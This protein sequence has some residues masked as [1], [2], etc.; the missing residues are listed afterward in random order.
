MKLSSTPTTDL[1]RPG[2]K[3]TKPSPRHLVLKHGKRILRNTKG[4]VPAPLEPGQEQLYSSYV[5]GVEAGLHR[6]DVTQNVVAGTECK[7]FSTSHQFNVIAPRF[8]LPE[9]A[10]DSIYPPPGHADLL[11]VLP[12]MVFNDPTLPWERIAS[13]GDERS[14]PA[15]FDFNRVPWLAVLLFTRDE[16]RVDPSALSTMFAGTSLGTAV[17]QSPTL[18]VPGVLA[19]EVGKILDTASSVAWDGSS[20]GA[21]AKTDLILVRSGLFNGL[22]TDW[23]PDGTGRKTQTTCCV[24]PYRYLAHVRHIHLHGTAAA[25]QTDDDDHAYS[26]V[27]SHRAGPLD[28]T[29][30]TP[31]VA[32]LV[33]IEAVEAM[34]WPVPASTPFVA[35]TSLYSWEY[36]C[37]PPHSFNVADAFRDLGDT[38]GR[39]RPC[40]SA[41]DRDQLQQAGGVGTRLAARLDDGFSLSRYRLPTG[42]VSSA[43]F[44]GPL[45]PNTVSFPPEQPAWPATST[46]GTKLQILDD[47]LNIMDITYSAAWA[48]G[49]TLALADQAFSAAL[50]RVRKQVF[51]EATNEAQISAIRAWS[52]DLGI[53]SPIRT[54]EEVVSTIAHT[55]Q[56]VAGL[57]RSRRLSQHARGMANRWLRRE[58]PALDLG[59]KSGAIDPEIDK[60]LQAA[61]KKV[62]SSAGDADVPY[63][64]HNVPYSTDWAVVLRWVM[65]RYFLAN[66]PAHYLIS[67]PSHLPPESLRFFY[68]DPAWVSALVDGGLSL[69]NHLDRD[70]DR[71]RDAI[72]GAINT[73]LTTTM[74]GLGYTPPVPTYG[75]LLRSALVTKFP[76]LIVD[77]KRKEQDGTKGEARQDNDSGPPVILRH[78]V[79]GPDT[80]L[81]LL[82]EYPVSPDFTSL[83]L[84][85]PPHQQYFSAAEDLSATGISMQYQR[86]YTDGAAEDEDK[87]RGI[88]YTLQRGVAPPLDR[89]VNFIW[90]TKDTAVDL[91]I[92][93]VENM[94]RDVRTQLIQLF[95]ALGHP[96]WYSEPY[97]TSAL[98][99]I[100]LSEPSWQLEFA[101][102]EKKK[103]TDATAVPPLPL[104][105]P[106]PLL[107]TKP[108]QPRTRNKAS[109][110]TDDHDRSGPACAPHPAF[111]DR[112]RAVPMRLA[113]PPPHARLPRPSSHP[114]ARFPARVKPPP[115][116]P[117]YG[118]SPS[119]VGIGSPGSPPSGPPVIEY[120]LYPIGAAAAGASEV[121]V[122]PG[123]QDL[124]FSLVLQP[125]TGQTFELEWLQLQV[126]LQPP[127]PLMDNYDGAGA[128]MLSNLRLN[129]LAQFA[130]ADDGRSPYLLLTLRPRS[131]TGSIPAAK[132]DEM[133]FLLSG[134]VVHKYA[135]SPVSVDIKVV[136]QYRDRGQ[137]GD[138]LYVRLVPPS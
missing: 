111:G 5:P 7:S 33:N 136:E 50:S 92:L 101:L 10:V 108:R 133:S 70:D 36:T 87:D 72:K 121:P 78:D 114:A 11:Q 74:P 60:H 69:A 134:V 13:H 98:M 77:F 110:G 53:R 124:V 129:V 38:L 109:W 6:I 96:E 18:T 21:D 54:R 135:G 16:L 137:W 55:V 88:P 48:L 58:L 47:Q 45:T 43:F 81:G 29:Q 51:D 14:H 9:K 85:Q 128:E 23:Q 104:P 113:H 75:F 4:S 65:D 34:A 2:W 44:R 59:Y 37:L 19:A 103:S 116:P 112:R 56:T 22:F 118:P 115:R 83:L 8:S 40:L 15:D 91:R 61:A 126:P 26:V 3:K 63:N 27:A 46:T 102:P 52:A 17:A 80:L 30:P 42:E 106:L 90:G 107:S 1:R 123:R 41:A 31:V 79:I 122:Q 99:G 93:N 130:P 76:D 117:Q 105:L 66:T 82:R 68:I 25:A 67:D 95:T 24:R 57:P 20:D 28:I 71:L 12:H 89:G 49:K 39:L 64:E 84:R 125:G 131:T 138:H 100:Q 62:A 73:C 97:P 119:A 94:A 86:V 32:H 132:I 127:R 120:K 35:V